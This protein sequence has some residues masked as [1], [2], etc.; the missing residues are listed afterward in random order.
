MNT[1][2]NADSSAD[3]KRKCKGCGVTY[4]IEEFVQSSAHRFDPPDRYDDGCDR[5]CLA[6]WL[7]VGPNDF[8]P[9]PE[10][11]ALETAWIPRITQG[12]APGTGRGGTNP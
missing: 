9:D 11:E 7:G 6:C 5:Y 2:S 1:E 12:Y 8:P 10:Q 4:T 3:R